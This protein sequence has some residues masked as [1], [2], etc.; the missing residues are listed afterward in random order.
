MEAF[1]HDLWQ[2]I[3]EPGQLRENL[4]Q[5]VETLGGPAT[6]A[7]LG[8]IVFAE[9]GLVVTPFLPGDSLLFATGAVAATVESVARERGVEPAINVWTMSLVLFVAAVVGDAVNYHVGRFIGPVAFDGRFRWL[10]KQH[11]ER[12]HA[13]FE[14]HG[15]R[16]VVIARFVPIVRT[17]APFVA[18]IGSMTYSRFAFYNVF[19]AFLWVGSL[20]TAGYLLG[21]LPFVQQHF[22]KVVLGII[23]VS[24]M[25]IAWEWWKVRREKKRS[26]KATAAG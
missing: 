16:A 11:L 13:F 14:K 7:M 20:V 4:A 1:L 15:G 6:Y 8:L 24:V 25:P 18:G 3:T 26:E 23:I 9:T 5:I 12:T 21:G 22:E 10:K 2:L 17:F 19:G